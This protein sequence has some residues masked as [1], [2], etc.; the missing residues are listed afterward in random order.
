MWSKYGSA[1]NARRVDHLEAAA[2][3]RCLVAQ[4]RRTDLV[5]DARG[6]PLQPVVAARGAMAGDEGDI[7]LLRAGEQPRQIGRI[8][9]A[10]AVDG[11]QPGAGSDLRRLPDRGALPG[12]GA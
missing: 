9:L 6:Q 1:R 12:T 2:G 10:V 4:H 5:G 11:G 7:A 3:V 8:V